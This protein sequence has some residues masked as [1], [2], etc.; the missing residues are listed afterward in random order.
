MEDTPSYGQSRPKR[1]DLTYAQIE[2]AATDILKTGVR[3]TVEGVRTALKG[4]SARTILDGLNRYWRDL[5]NQVAGT[6]DTLRRLP[7]AVADLAEGVWQR[8]LS[9][10]SDAAQASSTEADGQLSRLKSQLELRQHTLSQREVELDELLRSRERTLKELEEHL[11]AA[12][13]ML[14]KR[15]VTIAA[16]ESRLVAAEQETEDYRQ[17][18]AK[19]IQRAVTRQRRTSAKPM[20]KPKKLNRLPVR[21]KLGKSARKWT[22]KRR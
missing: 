18:L 14:T 19:V 1:A 6:P 20:P 17:R 2:R 21:P 3:P 12:L 11:R 9:L 7:A 13:S 15:D 4:G 10:A 5:G 22:R 16:L 8:A